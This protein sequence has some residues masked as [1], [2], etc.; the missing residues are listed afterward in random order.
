MKRT[1]TAV[2]SICILVSVLSACQQETSGAT[3]TPTVNLANGSWELLYDHY[4][5]QYIDLAPG[6]PL[7][8]FENKTK[9][10]WYSYAE[11]IGKVDNEALVWATNVVVSEDQNT[12]V[13]LSNKDCIDTG[14]MS[15][16]SFDLNTCEERILLKSENGTYY[17]V[18]FWLDDRTLLCLSSHNG[19]HQYVICDLDGN[20]TPVPFQGEQPSIYAHLGR[21]IAYQPNGGNS[22]TICFGHFDNF[23]QWVETNRLETK[24]GYP[25][26]GGAISPDGTLLAFPLRN[27]DPNNPARTINI[28]NI[29]SGALIPVPDPVIENINNPVAISPQQDE[30]G[31]FLEVL[32]T[33]TGADG[34]S[35]QQLWRYILPDVK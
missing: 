19:N 31:R 35:Q 17:G 32:Y 33:G 23:N 13:Y 29:P 9:E 22:N 8:K 10:E 18:F 27:P 21:L 25:I 7:P 16:F 30:R 26:N 3:P 28:W 11:S 14:G 1:L 5:R 24:G 6:L 4:N 12:V 20:V 2:L 34:N 15:V